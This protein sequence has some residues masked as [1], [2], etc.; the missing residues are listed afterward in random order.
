MKRFIQRIVRNIVLWAF[1]REDTMEHV[2]T[3]QRLLNRTIAIE[4]RLLNEMTEILN[5]PKK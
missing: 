2:I 1:D 5:K 3:M 4:G